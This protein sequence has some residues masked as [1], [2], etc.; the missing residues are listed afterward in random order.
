MDKIMVDNWFMED[1]VAD[2]RDQLT[3]IL[4]PYADLLN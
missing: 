3:H 4:K 1:I 2:I